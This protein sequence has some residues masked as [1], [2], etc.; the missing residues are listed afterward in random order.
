MRQL[1]VSLVT[2]CKTALRV[3]EFGGDSSGDLIA[4]VDYRDCTAVRGWYWLERP[5]AT[6]THGP[7]TGTGFDVVVMSG[8][9]AFQNLSSGALQEFYTG[10]VRK[11]IYP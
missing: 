9:P 4:L 11:P 6:Q 2:R 8:R 5:D 1:L 7:V 10:A 3:G